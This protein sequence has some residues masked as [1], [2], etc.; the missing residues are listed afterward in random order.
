M[1]DYIWLN[2]FAFVFMRFC[3]GFACFPLSCA[4]YSTTPLQAHPPPSHLN[5]ISEWENNNEKSGTE[6]IE[7]AIWIANY[8]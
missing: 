1:T 4:L 8:I 6:D 5:A 7:T 2:D 3:C